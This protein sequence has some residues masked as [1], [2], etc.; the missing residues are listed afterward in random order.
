MREVHIGNCRC[1]NADMEDVL[2][3]L[4]AMSVA[5]V[6]DPPYGIR[7]GPKAVEDWVIEMICKPFYGDLLFLDRNQFLKS[8]PPLAA[9]RMLN[10]IV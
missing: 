4:D 7:E 3:T 10:F 1:I 8:F 6:T 9:S 2:P 5:V